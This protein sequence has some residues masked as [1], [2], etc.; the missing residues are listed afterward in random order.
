MRHFLMDSTIGYCVGFVLGVMGG[1]LYKEQGAAHVA[2][3]ALLVFGVA[4]IW[5][6]TLALVLSKRQ[7][8]HNEEQAMR[9]SFLRRGPASRGK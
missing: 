3:A 8:R 6:L 9:E 4:G 5:S 2:G 1:S 7:A